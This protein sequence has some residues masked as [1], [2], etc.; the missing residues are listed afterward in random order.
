[1]IGFHL[2]PFKDR[3][4]YDSKHRNTDHIEPHRGLYGLNAWWR[5]RLT[6]KKIGS[7]VPRRCPRSRLEII[8]RGTTSS[9]RG[10]DLLHHGPVPTP[11][12][13]SVLFSS[14]KIRRDRGR[15]RA[16]P[17]GS[18]VLNSIGDRHPRLH[19]LSQGRSS[20]RRSSGVTWGAPPSPIPNYSSCV[21]N[22]PALNLLALPYSTPNRFHSAR[23]IACLFEPS[24]DQRKIARTFLSR[25][26]VQSTM[27]SDTRPS[28]PA[29]PVYTISGVS[30]GG[31]SPGLH[32]SRQSFSSTRP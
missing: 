22:F 27:N 29:P 16:L 9:V 19:L 31:V 4:C 23:R 15:S 20:T 1:M 30:S 8:E 26:S 2:K 14:C 7:D 12:R 13:F 10:I 25:S 17:S 6:A 21:P 24:S 32:L 3:V 11:G 5:P 28:R 18:P